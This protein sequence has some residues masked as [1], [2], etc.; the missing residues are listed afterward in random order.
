MF[1]ALPLLC[2]TNTCGAEGRALILDVAVES[3]RLDAARAE[4]ESILVRSAV[5]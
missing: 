4:R 2:S 1:T 3:V 5:G